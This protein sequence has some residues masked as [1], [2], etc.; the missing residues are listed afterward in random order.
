M[1]IH[2][3][4]TVQPAEWMRDKAVLQAI[5]REVF[6]LEQRV[7]EAEEWDDM[8][9]V[10][11]H[12]LAYAPDGL[13]IGTGRLLPD[14]RAGR[15]AVLQ[16]WRGQGAGRAILMALLAMARQSGFGEVLLHAQ[17]HALGFYGKH[18]FT[19]YGD[20]FMEAG[21]PH[22]EMRLQLNL[23]GGSGA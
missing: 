5:R 18:G 17:T 14:G 7:P 20:E 2:P 9:A 3:S 4:F 22:F 19:V 8:D 1:P 15:M 21:I 6:V 10:C 13:P 23:R 16:P 11:R 12:L